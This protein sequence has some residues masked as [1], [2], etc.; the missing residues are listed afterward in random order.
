M[1]LYE[2]SPK[3]IWQLSKKIKG[4]KPFKAQGKANKS[5][6]RTLP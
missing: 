3:E 5:G 6:T 1:K 2:E 4:I